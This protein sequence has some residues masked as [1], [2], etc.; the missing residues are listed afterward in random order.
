MLEKLQLT[1][2]A[3]VPALVKP[4]EFTCYLTIMVRDII[5]SILP[6]SSATGM[7]SVTELLIMLIVGIQ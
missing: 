4:S 3:G 1:C 2:M 5:T 7:V 6:V